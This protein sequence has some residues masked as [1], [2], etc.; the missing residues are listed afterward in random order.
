MAQYFS[1]YG[2]TVPIMEFNDENIRQIKDHL[3]QHQQTVAVAESVTA[4]LLQFALASADDAIHWS[5]S[6]TGYAT[7][8]HFSNY[9]GDISTI[10]A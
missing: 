9:W 10:K 8:G 6:I 5:I 3:L 4:G 7:P 1:L 2:E